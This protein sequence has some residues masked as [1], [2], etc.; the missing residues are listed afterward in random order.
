MATAI[1]VSQH[2]GNAYWHSGPFGYWPDGTKFSNFPSGWEATLIQ[3]DSG[4]YLE[5]YNQLTDTKE[6]V[7]LPQA[8]ALYTPQ[9]LWWECGPHSPRYTESP[10]EHS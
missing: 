6:T 2:G 8:L 4:D 10:K 3:K 7:A 1:L 9:D 5:W